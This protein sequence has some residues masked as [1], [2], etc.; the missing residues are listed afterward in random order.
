MDRKGS[1]NPLLASGNIRRSSFAWNLLSASA[2]SFQTMLLLIVITRFGTDTDSA[3]FVMAY[4]A[5]N[6][7]FIS[8]MR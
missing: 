4:A 8:T 3:A 2:N 6:L 5:G 7:F 1:R